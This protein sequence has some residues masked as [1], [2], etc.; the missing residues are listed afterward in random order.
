MPEALTDAEMLD[1]FE[2]QVRRRVDNGHGWTH[3]RL[4]PVVR[5]TAPSWSGFGGGVFVSDLGRLT[6]AEVDAAIADE[7]AYF[8]GLGKPWEWKLYAHDLPADLSVRLVSAGLKPEE[9]EALVVGEVGVVL[10]ACTDTTVPTG[11]TLREFVDDDHDALAVLLEAEWGDG[12][13]VVR[14]LRREQAVD[15]A[16][17]RIHVAAAGQE[18]VSAGWIRFHE[19]TQFASLWG[20]ST[21]AQWRRRGIY[22]ALVARRAE[23]A[24]ALGLR[25]LQVDASPDSRPILERLGLHVVSTTT[26]YAGG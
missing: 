11:V 4:G 18:I 22:R 12:E 20:G 3:E 14:D 24:R 17:M 10:A 26:P 9:E 5:S 16:R 25:F 19:D 6:A 15:P 21:A 1:A 7:V 8:S 13:A 23:Q 2:T